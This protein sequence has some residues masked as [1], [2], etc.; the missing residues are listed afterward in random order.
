VPLHWRCLKL[1]SHPAAGTHNQTVRHY[2]EPESVKRRLLALDQ[3]TTAQQQALEELQ[4]SSDPVALLET[5]RH[6]QASL[7]SLS[8]G[9]Q[10]QEP[11]PGR[12]AIDPELLSKEQ[13]TLSRFQRN[14]Q[15]LWQNSQPHPE[16]RQRRR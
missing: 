5:I 16:P 11:Q 12:G 15:V 6:C 2:A 14:L 7:A 8:A 9:I 1:G 13:W 4:H 10:G 3:L